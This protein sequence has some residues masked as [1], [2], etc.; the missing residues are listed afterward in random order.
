LEAMGF[1][2]LRDLVKSMTITNSLGERQTFLS[3]PPGSQQSAVVSFALGGRRLIAGGETSSRAHAG[4][5]TVRALRLTHTRTHACMQ[6]CV[7]DLPCRDPRNVLP[8]FAPAAEAKLVLLVHKASTVDELADATRLV[9]LN[10]VRATRFKHYDPYSSSMPNALLQV[11]CCG[12]AVSALRCRPWRKMA[13]APGHRD[14]RPQLRLRALLQLIRPLTA[15]M[16]GSLF[17][18][19]PDTALSR[20][21]Y[22]AR[23][24]L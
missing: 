13:P 17:A 8:P 21:P 20:A 19:T 10:R 16:H 12:A 6:A 3:L 22:C 1:A 18:C 2:E 9:H 5:G 23:R 4:R 11:G 7:R 14:G 24:T 15:L